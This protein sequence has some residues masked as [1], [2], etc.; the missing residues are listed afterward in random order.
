MPF[1]QNMWDLQRFCEKKNCSGHKWVKQYLDR[2]GKRIKRFK[3][4]FPG[5]E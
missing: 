2:K 5:V 3:N 4:N 1:D